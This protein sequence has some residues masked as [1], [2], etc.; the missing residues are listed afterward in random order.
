MSG[1]SIVVVAIGDT[2]A[3]SFESL[4]E[5]IVKAIR[6]ADWVIHVGDF[7]SKDVFD[8]LVKLKRDRFRGVYGNA[9]PQSIRSRL[10]NKAI[11]EIS[12]RRIGFTHPSVGG[13]DDDTEDIVITEFERDNVDVI[14]YG[15]THESK[16]QKIDGTLLISQ[17]KGY[18]E[19]SYFGPP[20]SIAV[21]TIGEEIVGEIVEIG[22]QRPVDS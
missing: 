13:P 22:S 9:D 14:I 12:G 21:L 15:H 6:S 3:Y 10:P 16:I 18:L 19:H 1:Q 8:G 7:V 11:I 20:T 17:G 4:A 5:D 2:H